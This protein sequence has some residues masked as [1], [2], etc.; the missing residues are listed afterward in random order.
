M[1][2]Y[3][4]YY[5]PVLLWMVGIFI[6]SSRQSVDVSEELIINFIVFKTIHVI[7]YAILF[8]LWFRAL[9]SGSDNESKI[10]ASLKYAFGAALIY[11]ISDEV[12]Q[13]FVPTR[14]G[15]LRDVFIDLIGISLMYI[16]IKNNFRFVKRLL[17]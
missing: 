5:A 8:M 6:M 7:E 15:A 4:W 14:Q 10:G 11:A 16:Y 9:Q 3:F 13:T 12:H 2:K 1:K 17:R